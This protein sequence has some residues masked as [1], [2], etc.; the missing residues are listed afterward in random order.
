[1]SVKSKFVELDSMYMGL[2]AYI[3]KSIRCI[4]T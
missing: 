3:K 1:M 4:Y 2:I